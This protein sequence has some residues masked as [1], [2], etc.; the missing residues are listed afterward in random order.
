MAASSRP[1]SAMPAKAQRQPSRWASTPPVAMPST[2]PNMPPEMKAPDR[3]ARI[4]R[5]NTDTTTAMPTLP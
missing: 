3:V 5:G 4:S 1:N 2:E